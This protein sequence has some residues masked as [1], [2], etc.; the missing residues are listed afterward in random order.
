MIAGNIQ[1]SGLVSLEPRPL[2]TTEHS[3]E[4][5]LGGD[6]SRA[7]SSCSQIANIKQLH[8][9]QSQHTAKASSS[10]EESGIFDYYK[11]SVNETNG[12]RQSRD[13]AHLS[14][15]REDLNEFVGEMK[16]DELGGKIN[17]DPAHM[18]I[19]ESYRQGFNYGGQQ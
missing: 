17:Q 16:L 10:Q 11:R 14:S 4:K 15:V 5:L 18:R 13:A 9:N 8:H 3:T 19:V 12:F 2:L 1:Q 6:I 7:G